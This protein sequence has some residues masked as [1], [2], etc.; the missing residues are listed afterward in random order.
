MTLPPIDQAFLEKFLIDLLNIPSPTGFTEKAT[1]FCQETLSAFPGVQ[2]SLTRK[3]ALLASYPGQKQD[4]PRAITSHVDTNGAMVKDV[5]ANGR[6]QLMHI[7]ST[8]WPTVET[9]G[10]TV[11]TSDGRQYRGSL[12]FH[13][14]SHH[15]YSRELMDTLR[16][17][18]NM[19]VRLDERTTN[20]EETLALG[21]QAGD[22]VAFDV[23]AESRNGFIR[24]R[25]LDDK[26][27]VA[28]QVAAA[29]ALH[30]AGL[31]PSQKAYLYFSIFE[32]VGHGGSSGIPA[33]TIEL[34]V[35]D[36]AAIGE[37]Q[38]S[39][40]FH[41]TLCVMDST[42]PYHHPFSNRLRRLAE[43]NDIPYKVDI[44][45]YYGSDGSTY[46]RAGGDGVVALIG[47]GIDA[48][49]N[50]ERTHME[51]LLATTRW[52]LAFLLE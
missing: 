48:S 33:D 30:D 3:G 39:D 35:A 44:Y 9:E 19:E 16:K 32:E 21:I 37:T 20:K 31:Q 28:C 40:E 10:C 18:D 7:G 52:M 4:T 26:A 2:T 50:Y 12:L 43:Q 38:T 1:A 25:Y 24:S 49:H 11:F 23:R 36:M 27:C 17:S 51:A 6:L 15:V 8:L 34:M 13:H 47:P 45:P 14:A 46:W 42:G 22:Y 41:A 29:K 5:K